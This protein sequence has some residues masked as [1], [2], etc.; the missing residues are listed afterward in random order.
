MTPSAANAIAWD[1][2]PE[3]RVRALLERGRS[4]AMQRRR[5]QRLIVLF[6]QAA[7]IL[8]LLGAWDLASGRL[9]DADAISD[10]VSVASALWSLVVSGRIW[11]DLWQTVEEVLLGFGFG[12]VIGLGLALGF[13]LAPSAQAVLRPFLIAFYAIPKI[14]L[15][16]LIVMWLGLDT[17]PKVVM[18]ATFVF[19]VVFM[20]AVG[21]IEAVN[22][23][24]VMLARIMSADRLTIL[25]KIVLPSTLPFLLV[26]FR[27]AIPEA[28]IGA[29]IGEFI[30]S[31]RGLGH[32]VSSASSQ[33]NMAVSLA[34]I[35][36]L[37]GIVV[38]ADVLLSAIEQR[39][40]RFQAGW[41][42]GPVART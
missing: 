21:G 11:P 17:L 1:A 36:V 32:L 23:Q 26:G 4:A 10:P 18:A 29:V 33:F 5:S 3:N 14:A 9:V 39:T 34:A 15:A 30:V 12:S 42:N 31:D 16:P 41:A 2:R 38:A 19:F 22:P 13:A 28:V 35:L 37:L 8:F 40:L 20:N 27:L 6:G 24:H 25:R 7:T